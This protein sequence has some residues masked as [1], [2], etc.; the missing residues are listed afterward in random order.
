MTDLKRRTDIKQG[1]DLAREIHARGRPWCVVCGKFVEGIEETRPNLSLK[2]E[3]QKE[4]M[5]VRIRCHGK[6]MSAVLNADDLG[7]AGVTGARYGLAFVEEALKLGIPIPSLEDEP[8]TPYALEGDGTE[9]P[10]D[11]PSR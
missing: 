4:Q 1:T 11:E 9:V 5:L 6:F 7:R 2:Y 3:N 10:E 8:T